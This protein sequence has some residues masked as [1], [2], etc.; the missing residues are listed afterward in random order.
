MRQFKS[1]LHVERLDD[2]EV[3]GLLNGDCYI[4]PKMDGTNASIWYNENENIIECG[5]R[6]RKISPSKDNAGFADWVYNS[7]DDEIVKIRTFLKDHEN[8]VLYGEWGCGRIAAIKDYDSGTASVFWI[9]AAYDDSAQRYLPY[10]DYFTLL[11]GYDLEDYL[12][13]TIGILKNPT[14]DQIDKLAQSNKFRLKNTNHPGEGVVIYNYDYINPFGRFAVGKYVLDSYV[15]G[16]RKSQ[17]KVEFDGS[18]EQYFVDKYVTDVELS[19]AR[20]KIGNAFG[21]KDSES[22]GK[23]LQL[24]WTDALSENIVAFLKH[25]KNPT[26]NFAILKKLVFDKARKF[27]GLV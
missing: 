3:D 2:P 20:E 22:V 1:F 11:N 25:R 10:T 13:P 4:F 8:L 6:I 14:I 26:V 9:F 23:F 16:K 7:T 27:I 19:K 18:H 15:A 21:R 24:V 17:K 5:S 12:I